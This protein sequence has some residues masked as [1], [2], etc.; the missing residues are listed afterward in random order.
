VQVLVRIDVGPVGL[1][2]QDVVIRRH[3]N[4]RATGRNGLVRP[5]VVAGVSLRL[6]DRQHRAGQIQDTLDL[7]PVRAR[8]VV[9][10]R[11]VKHQ[12]ATQTQRYLRLVRRGRIP[13]VSRIGRADRLVE[14]VGQGQTS[15]KRR[16]SRIDIFVGQN[17]LRGEDGHVSEGAPRCDSSTGRTGDQER[18]RRNGTEL[19]DSWMVFHGYVSPWLFS[20]PVHVRNTP[21]RGKEQ[22]RFVLGSI[23]DNPDFHRLPHHAMNHGGGCKPHPAPTRAMNRHAPRHHPKFPCYPDLPAPGP[24][25]GRKQFLPDPRSVSLANWKHSQYVRQIIRRSLTQIKRKTR[26]R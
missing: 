21:K 19:M 5:A 23:G 17:L 3:R 7:R 13:F 11:V 20:P 18:G 15:P 8:L 2:H 9:K 12:V 25:I 6:P 26:S 24:V 1:Q 10:L 22:Y 14:G 4:D 16:G